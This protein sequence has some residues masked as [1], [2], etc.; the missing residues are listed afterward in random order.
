MFI[1][2]L[3]IPMLVARP[4]KTGFA[5]FPL[6]VSFCL[7][8][9]C[10][11]VLAGA[12]H[13]APSPLHAQGMQIVDAGGR[14]VTLRGVNL[15]GWL[16]EEPWMQPFAAT[17]PAGSGFAPIKDHVSLWGT[18]QKR[19]GTAGMQRA[20]TA[21][22]TAW[23]TEGDF[24]RLHAL[25][26]N[27][28]RLP[29]LASLLDEPGG[30]QWLDKAIAWAGARG[31]Y[32]VLD[33]HGAPGGQS[34]QGHT[35][36]ANVNA[37][38][39]N[40]ANIA[41]GMAVW[42]RLARRCQANPAVAGY[43]LLNEPTG[44]PNSDTLYVVQG[45]LYNAIRATDTRHIIFIEDGYT[46]VQWMPFPGP[47][48]WQNV[49]YSTHYYDFGAKSAPDQAQASAGYVASLEAERARRRIPYYVGEFGLEPGGTP[50]TLASLLNTLQSKHFSY[51]SWTYKVC[52]TG[53]G[54]SLWALYSNVKPLEAL[55]PYR[56]SEA[57]WVRKC[58]QL[59]TEHLDENTA[60]ADVFR[61]ASSQ[62]KPSASSAPP[63]A[64][65]LSRP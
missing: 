33:M 20:R 24:D 52:W 42:A 5:F 47:C 65:P 57:E 40:P 10:V 1:P 54:Q 13:S 17:P 39:A 23:V 35:G 29:F 61:N 27:C 6:F 56:D 9:A 45:R 43:D 14:T 32:V 63:S 34:D 58:A 44:T 21:F 25:G 11:L 12:A 50:S 19:L 53:G 38:F 28:V 3:F 8:L 49:A 55:D 60:M 36:Q 7:M 41:R 64:A 16:V 18:L 51:S 4:P 37:F 26:F 46:G 59:R 2:P 15:G 48:G 22:R 30:V 62:A 31:M